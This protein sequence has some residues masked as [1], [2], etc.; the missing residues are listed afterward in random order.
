MASGDFSA[1]SW[2]QM[3]SATALFLESKPGCPLSLQRDGPSLILKKSTS[4]WTETYKIIVVNDLADNCSL[5]WSIVY[6][7]MLL[8]QDEAG[9]DWLMPCKHFAD[10][11][12][13][14]D[15]RCWQLWQLLYIGQVAEFHLYRSGP[16]RCPIH[17]YFQL[18]FT[19]NDTDERGTKKRWG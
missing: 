19:G 17:Q 1:R 12:T 5:F 7:R 10:S 11:T 13:P 3:C 6:S 2:K 4:C 9:S 14:C 8:R 16:A 15:T 18:T